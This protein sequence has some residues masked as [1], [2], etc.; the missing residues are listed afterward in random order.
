MIK[1][2][3]IANRG[4][5][6]VRIIRTC[7]EMGI[8]T[9]AVFSDVDRSSP[10]VLLATEA[11]PIGSAP[12][13]RSYLRAEKILDVAKSS[14]ADAVHPG[15]GFLSENGEFAAAVREAGFT[16]IGP[17]TDAMAKMGDKVSAR[18]L[19]MEEGVPVVPGSEMPVV[20]KT[21]AIELARI[22]GF[23]VMVKAVGGGGGKG[24]RIVNST[25]ELPGALERAMSE[26]A[27]SFSDRRVFIEKLLQRPRHIEIQVMADSHGHCVPLRER[28]CSIQRR[29]QKLI[30]ESPSTFIDNK[31]WRK[32]AQSAVAIT[33]RSGYTGVGTV[34][35]LVDGNKNFYFLEMNTRLQVEHPV[36][37]M[38][39]GIDLV[40][41]QIRVADGE[42]LSIEGD[43]GDYLGHAIECRVY[44]EDG[45]ADFIPSTGTIAELDIPGGFG[46]R[47]DHG[48]RVGQ[49]ITPHY[50]PILGKLVAWGKNRGEAISRMRRALKECHIMGV[51]TTIPFCLAVL[52]H[53]G[54]RSGDYDTEFISA[55]T[56]NLRKDGDKKRRIHHQIAS[57]LT[58]IHRSDLG[59]KTKINGRPASP[60]SIWKS[61]GRKDALR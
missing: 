22:I 50:D 29:Y 26:S 55:E 38:I 46:I 44:A 6:A 33:R 27:S 23:P 52:S 51:Q 13:A 42:T 1:K 9:V 16:W 17:P 3:L 41:E 40:R 19:A 8:H 61:S 11:F 45:F 59:N 14:G 54:F 30:E 60:R 32:M 15:Y 24:I 7:H 48:I 56:G 18:K 28:E 34:E 25:E 21:G 58:A 20:E 53:P 57:V 10:H 31:L 12:S 2:V 4:E 5:I 39:T 37:E 49:R 36:T 35:F 43:Q 47:F